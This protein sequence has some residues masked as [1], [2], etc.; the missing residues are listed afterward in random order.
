MFFGFWIFH[1]AHLLHSLIS[2]M[3]SQNLMKSK[4]F[5][6]I[7]HLVEVLIILVCGLLPSIVIVST[8]GYQ[9]V[10]FPPVCNS[11]IPDVFFYTLIFPISIEATIG[12]C[13]LLV[14]LWLLH[15]VTD[16]Q[17][18]YLIIF[19]IINYIVIIKLGDVI[20]IL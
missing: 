17:L 8:S 18:L 15:K 6:R 11:K 4:R 7:V 1:L 9:F 5:R 13:M 20:I 3:R 16:I 2:P 10:G 12:L 19:I 14:S